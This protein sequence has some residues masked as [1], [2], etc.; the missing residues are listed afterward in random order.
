MSL[1]TERFQF[2]FVLQE[3]ESASSNMQY[4]K[5]A[6]LPWQQALMQDSAARTGAELNTSSVA[7]PADS[8]VSPIR[9]SVSA[10]LDHSRAQSCAG[11]AKD[12]ADS[13]KT[14]KQ[15]VASDVRRDCLEAAQSEQRSSVSA[16][17]DHSRAQSC[18]GTT[19]DNTGP[20]KT[21]KHSDVNTA[22]SSERPDLNMAVSNE[23]PDLNTAVSSEHPDLNTAV[24]I[25]HPDLNT[26]VSIEH[27][28]LN[29]AVSSEHQELNTA[30]SSEH[31]D[32]STA[33]GTVSVGASGNQKSIPQKCSELKTISRQENTTEQV[34]SSLKVASLQEEKTDQRISNRNA[35]LLQ[36]A[37]AL[38]HSTV[39][40]VNSPFALSELCL[41]TLESSAAQTRTLP[42]TDAAGDLKSKHTAAV[43]RKR[44]NPEGTE[45]GDGPGG[46]SD[47]ESCP[48]RK[49]I[50]CAR[51]NKD[52]GRETDTPGA[53]SEREKGT[54][55]EDSAG[56]ACVDAWSPESELSVFVPRPCC[57]EEYL[58]LIKRS[59]QEDQGTSS[60]LEEDIKDGAAGGSAGEE[61]EGK[62]LAGVQEALL[63]SVLHPDVVKLIVEKL[64]EQV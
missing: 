28:D 38:Q 23:H 21:N 19:T 34:D 25:V 62:C 31:P 1:T 17:L 61:G 39:R 30:V 2:C 8:C 53:C 47:Q 59:D 24:S 15:G 45:K 18:A 51:E 26:T 42:N 16:E 7:R 35:R 20:R 52:G 12:N 64:K 36:L 32:L 4:L 58:K 6:L 11:T 27:P 43:P 41:E 33:A 56:E 14:N 55:G 57:L 60:S 50:F 3:L 63:K 54:R 22:V 13:G 40:C 37:R 5:A 49:K 48:Q 10:E 46:Q 9:S 44:K 29:T